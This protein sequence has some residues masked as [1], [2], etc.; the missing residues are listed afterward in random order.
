MRKL[1][2]DRD[3]RQMSPAERDAELSTL[4]A[5]TKVVCKDDLKNIDREIVA[6]EQKHE[7]RSR[8]LLAQLAAGERAENDEVC[9][10]LMLL[11]R[12]KRLGARIEA[13]QARTE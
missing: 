9:R 5:G 4:L 10:W 7:L 6:L 1:L 12:R 8:D 3:L 13:A 11:N 2:Y